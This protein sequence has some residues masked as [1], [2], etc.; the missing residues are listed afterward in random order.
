MALSYPPLPNPIVFTAA[1]PQ[2]QLPTEL[3]ARLL[4]YVESFNPGFTATL[5]ASLIEDISSTSVGAIALC[6]QAWVDLLN[7]IAPSRANPYLLNI[8]GQIYGPKPNAPT[9]TSVFVV[10]SGP[11]G[12]L[13]AEGFLVGDGTYQYQ[14]QYPGGIVSADGATEPLFC[15]A[16]VPGTWAV[17]E[18]TVD[19]L[20]SSVPSTISLSVTNPSTGIPGN[21]DVETEQSYRARVMQAGLA[22]AQGTPN[23]LR[24]L[25]G[26]VEGVQQRLIG[27]R[28][29]D[30][31]WEIIVGGGDPY[32][33]AFA[34]Y[35]ALGPGIASLTGS[36]LHVTGITQAN[37][38]VVTTDL[39]THYEDGQVVVLS[40]CDP[41]DYDGTYT[42]T[43]L[44]PKT[45]SLGV[46]TSGLPA[47]V[48]D[49]IATPNFRNITPDVLDY[50]D[51]YAIPIVIPPEQTVDVALT[52]NTVDQNFVSNVAV[53]QLGIP[54]LVDYIN[55]IIVGQ[56]I[57]LFEL[58]DVF[59]QAVAPLIPPALLT[60]M[61]FAVSVDG[62]GVPPES[63]TGIIAGDPESFFFT[64]A[65]RIVVTKG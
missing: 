62:V 14:V 23:M 21:P 51:V 31:R 33:V 41:D 35:L 58:Q 18:N 38:G 6:D 48:G 44:G 49:G 64:E 65:S 17:P 42:I 11:P 19:Q 25:V 3:L 55:S 39:D 8:L 63:G 26:E 28:L 10:F 20:L 61:V 27:V 7:S 9:N 40:N 54:A 60:R 53:A 1:G 46:N 56:P 32:Q 45:F 13:V 22:T 29:S 15:I 52:W 47:Y 30:G 4:A 5:P 2:P 24:A 12:F 37:P 36:T 50:P 34:I 59:Q 57:N 16:T 43:V